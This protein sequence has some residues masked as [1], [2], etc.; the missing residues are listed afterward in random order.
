MKLEIETYKDASNV[1]HVY[2]IYFFDGEKSKSFFIKDYD[3]L[4]NM[5]IDLFKSLFTSKK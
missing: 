5:L 4:D 3:S 1:M 2:C